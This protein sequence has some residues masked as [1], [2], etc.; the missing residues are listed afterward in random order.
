MK[1]ILGLD[2]GSASIGW[3]LAYEPESEDEQRI[4]AAMG[5]RIIPLTGNDTD[6]FSKKNA[7]SNNAARTQKRGMRRNIFRYKLRRDHLRKILEK[8]GMF[9]TKEFFELSAIDLYSLRDKAL[10]EEITLQELGR[11]LFHMNQKRGYKSN[12]KAQNKEEAKDL[13]ENTGSSKTSKK[14][15]LDLIAEREQVLSKKNITIGQYIYLQLCVDPLFRVKENIFM[16]SSYIDEFNKIWEFQCKYNPTVLNEINKKQ[17]RD[18]II[19]YQRH[20]RSQKG[21]VS[22]CEFERKSYKDKRCGY[23]KDVISG[24][25]VA[26]KS[27]PLF[28]VSKIWQELNNIEITCF[29]SMKNRSSLTISKSGD[30]FDAQGKRF[31]TQEEKVKLFNKLNW[32]EKLTPQ[33]ILKELGYMS[34]FNEYKI[35]LRNEKFMEGNRTLTAIR[36]VFDKHKIQK[37]G[38][39]KFDLLKSNDR[40]DIDTG[41]FLC[42]INSSFEAEPLY[43]LW[44]LIYSVDSTETLEHVLMNKY[45]FSQLVAK[46]LAKIDF[47]KQGYGSLSARALRNILP[48]LMKGEQYSM[49]CENAG[50]NHSN[51]LTKIE[52]G[53]RSLQDKLDLYPKNSLRQPV[54]EKVVNQVINLINDIINPE[55]GLLTDEERKAKDSKFEIRVELARDLRQSKEERIKAFDANSKADKYHKEI[56][57][58]LRKDLGFKRVSQ[59]DIIRY[60]LWKEFGYV[61]PY[62]PNKVISLKEV[63]NLEEGVLY[64]IEHIIPRSRLFDDSFSNKTLCPKA[65]NSGTGGK[66]QDTAYDFMNKQGD[67]KFHDYIEFIKSHLNKKDISFSKYSK[68]MMPGDKIPDDFIERQMQETRYISREV[69]ALLQKVCRNVYSTTGSITAKLRQLW[70]WDEVLMNLHI[71]KYRQQSQTEQIELNRCGQ[72]HQKERIK[73]WTKR[74]DHRHHTI[75]A[76]CV[77]CTTQEMI[78]KISSLN[79]AYTQKENCSNNDYNKRISSLDTYLINQ[80]P[81]TTWQVEAAASKVLVSFKKGK[82]VGVL[83]KNVINGEVVKMIVPRGRLHEETAYGKIMQYNKEGRLDSQIVLKC[84]VGF[85]NSGFLFTGKEAKSIK[86]KINRKTG[87]VQRVEKDSLALVLESIIDRRVRMAVSE[88]LSLNNNEI[89]N[90]HFDSEPIWFDEKNKIPI[91]S[92]RCKIA[93][94]NLAQLKHGLFQLGN[95]HHIAIYKDKDGSLYENVV[96]FW[97]AFER[98]KMGLPIIVKSPSDLWTHI[99]DTSIDDDLILENLPKD[100]LEYVT[101]MQQNEMFIFGFSIEDLKIHIDKNNY[102]LLNQKLY[103]VQKIATKNYYFRLHTETKVDDKYNGKKDE[104]LSKRLGNVIIVQSL[105]NMTGIKVNVDRLGIITLID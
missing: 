23:E 61:S 20:L 104:M 101:S 2:L 54:V 39:L 58:I 66:N 63:F 96:T 73:D 68:L 45:K 44:H 11:I 48:F 26:P 17:I 103:R 14:G 27:S 92:V 99:I 21:L 13:N 18:E 97:E 51:S 32:G 95:N 62:E 10:K 94:N 90:C 7:I 35:N 82:R 69:H 56:V 29:Q 98:K 52:N 25:M 71:D 9:P 88:R 53:L 28:Q 30:G 46:D 60:K 75:D 33:D 3:A 89:K 87:E 74:L 70:G 80:Q 5:V 84:K 65:M 55:N 77:A 6:V 40:P 1:K 57:D 43:Q 105:T 50:Y 76:L 36:K 67:E 91:K 16:R 42:R 15:Y 24:P 86:E 31:L 38:L 37:D 22:V 8:L 72:I 47:L 34:G 19:Y 100:G 79:A 102:Q 78:Q 64:E 59:N 12:R 81:F 83:S 85:G 49:A 4:I 41:G 93:K